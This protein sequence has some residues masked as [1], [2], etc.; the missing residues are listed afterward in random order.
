MVPNGTAY[1][2]F[3][4]FADSGTRTAPGSAKYA[5]GYLPGETYPAEWANYFMHGATS[6]ITRLNADTVSIKKELNSILAAYGIA[7]D[8]DAYDQLLS[9]I[10]K[11]Y[12]Q[13]CTCSTAGATE[14]KSVSLTGNV[15][16]AGCIYSITMTH[17]NTY[18]D[19]TTTYPKLS[20]NSGTSYPLCNSNGAYLKSGAWADG[21][22]I[23]VLF[24]GTKYLMATNIVD[25]AE[26]GNMA[27]ITSNAA[28]GITPIGSVL[29]FAGSTAPAGYLLCNGQAVSRTT[30]SALFEVLGTTYG[31]GDGT[32]TFN[33]PDYRE[34][35][36]VG[37]GSNTND[38][39]AT[40]DS[41]TVGEF[42]DDA[43][44]KITGKVYF[45]NMRTDADIF[46]LTSTGSFS[47][48]TASSQAS[49]VQ[50]ASAPGHVGSLNFNSASTTRNDAN[51][52]VTRGK[53]KGVNYIIKAL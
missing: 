2:D 43:L 9:V 6:G 12:P 1:A 41:Y 27:A 3:P 21:E 23:T 13:I 14:V 46:A 8:A 4:S 17:G 48:G 26:P 28:Y 45:R 39:I 44:Q 50:E 53:R 20:F 11:I 31:A 16:K 10:N 5:Q 18:G 24:T 22:T 36:L 15:L 30:Y 52:N 29:A 47:T 51:A 42:K 33:V 38:T 40:H 34:C 37:A 35:A 19:G 25:K 49:G 7:N 32:E